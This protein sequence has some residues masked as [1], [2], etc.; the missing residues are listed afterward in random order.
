M[1]YKLLLYRLLRVDPITF[2]LFYE[3]EQCLTSEAMDSYFVF[4]LDNN[5]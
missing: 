5:E 1:W 2:I 3:I 4:S